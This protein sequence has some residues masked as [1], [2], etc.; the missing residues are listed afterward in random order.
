[1]ND[2]PDLDGDIIP[3]HD[4]EDCKIPS[5]PRCHDYR[6]GWNAGL[7]AVADI[8]VHHPADCG[9]GVCLQWRTAMGK[10]WLVREH[11]GSA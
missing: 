9:C 10:E 7:E 6:L 5:C 1:M 4:G 3:D 11:Y 8:Y 2:T